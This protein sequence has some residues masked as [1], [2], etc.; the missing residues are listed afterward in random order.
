MAQG[1]NMVTHPHL[2]PRL[3]ISGVL[4]LRPL[5]LSGVRKDKLAP[6]LLNRVFLKI[7]RSLLTQTRNLATV[8]QLN[9]IDRTR[10]AKMQQIF[11]INLSLFCLH[12]L[13]SIS[14]KAKQSAFTVINLECTLVQALRLCTGRTAQRGN[15]GIALLFH[16]HGTR[17][18]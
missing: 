17:R 2:V 14:G 3:R 4:P 12:H 5:C 16:D 8:L 18:R 9:A 6:P 11:T 1:F 13:C 10:D 15:R 7:F